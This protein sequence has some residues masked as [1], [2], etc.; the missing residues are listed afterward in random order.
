MKKYLLISTA[1]FSLSLGL[2]QVHASDIKEESTAKAVGR[3]V[4]RKVVGAA[5]VGSVAAATSFGKDEY[6]TY[7]SSSVFIREEVDQNIPFV[8]PTLTSFGIARMQG[9]NWF[10]STLIAAA[11]LGGS[12]FGASKQVLLDTF[13]FE[14]SNSQDLA[15]A[16]GVG[17]GAGYFLG[18]VI[19]DGY[20]WIGSK[21][22][23]KSTAKKKKSE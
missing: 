14:L 16:T 20:H 6:K 17:A 23:R 13:K 11:T 5:T 8:T 7:T 21:M 2:T 18:T 4:V 10:D 22:L 19:V 12:V 3:V 1:L 9:Y 15:L